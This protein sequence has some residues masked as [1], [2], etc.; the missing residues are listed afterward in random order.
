MRPTTPR[1]RR[2]F[3]PW[4]AVTL[5]LVQGMGELLALQ[6]SHRQRR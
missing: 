3:L 4:L 6:R 2:P 1:K 5:A